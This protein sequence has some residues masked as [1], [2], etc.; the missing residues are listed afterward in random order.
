M[1]KT[2]PPVSKFM[3]PTPHTVERHATLAKASLLM[4]QHAIRH[5]PV[6]D[7]NRLLGIITERD[8]RFAQSFDIVDPEK[9]SVY[10]AMAEELY[11]TS[12]D[13]PIDEVV[14]TMAQRKLGSAVIVQDQRVVG[15]LT[16]VDVCR[17]FSEFLRAGLGN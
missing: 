8:I 14:S 7:G 11:S 9:V 2:T 13:T 10:G 16:T 15:L 4:Q 17:A 1:S 5:L 3:T 12:P 6:M